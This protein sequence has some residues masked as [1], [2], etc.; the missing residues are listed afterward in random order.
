MTVRRAQV[1]RQNPAYRPATDPYSCVMHRHRHA[2]RIVVTILPL[3]SA[4]CSR[5]VVTPPAPVVAPPPEAP[6]VVLAPTRTVVASSV[7]DAR[8]EVRTIARVS[9][10]SAGRSTE[11]R[12]ESRAL[13]TTSLQRAANGDF[14]GSGRIDS[15]TVRG[16]ALAF[17]TTAKTQTSQPVSLDR[18]V[19]DAVLDAQSLR[20]VAR[21]LL[22]NEC[23]RPETGAMSLAREVLVRVPT[24][25]LAGDKWTDSSITL[26]CRSGVPIAVRVRSDYVIERIDTRTN[27]LLLRRSMVT[28]LDGKLTSTWRTLDVTGTGSGTQQ[29]IVDMTRGTV[30]RIDGNSTVTMQVTERNRTNAPRT[31]RVV[32]HVELR[33]ESRP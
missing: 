19:F 17:D 31:H 4:A 27:V 11:Q 5:P 30:Q 10:D 16:P 32:Q 20:V 25:V 13:V 33:V 7:R 6:P 14:R 15:F 8:Y 24:S 22:A 1:R 26:V 28:R 23:D 2:I 3:W 18:M 29:I 12:I 21:P 9:R